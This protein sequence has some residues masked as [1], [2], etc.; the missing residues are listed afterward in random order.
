MK[1]AHQLTLLAA[2]AVTPIAFAQDDPGPRQPGNR[3]GQGGG[4][5]QG[6]SV[7]REVPFEQATKDFKADEGVFTVWRKEE[8][9]LFEIPN[10]LMGRDFLWYGELKGAP[11]GG[12]SGSSAFDNLV[13]WEVRGNKVLLKDISY[14]IKAAPGTAIEEGVRISN[15]DP[16]IAVFDI[17]SKTPK[18]TLIDVSRFLKSDTPE[19]ST[20]AAVPGAGSMD[21]SRTFLERI[22]SFPENINYEILATFNPGATGAANPFSRRQAGGGTQTA[23]VHHSFVLLAEKPMMGRIADSRVG[24]F[25]NSYQDF[26]APGYQG[27]KEYRYINRYRLEKKDPNAKVSE[28]V[29]PIVYYVAKEVPEEW[30]EYVKQGIEDWQPA[31]EQAGFK[32]A[33]IAKD[34]PDDPEWSPEDVR[35]SVVR[36]A[37][38]PIANALGPSVADPRSG[39]I[40][41]A[42]VIMWHDILKLQQEWYFTQASASDPR[43]RKFPY[44]K[45]LMGELMRFVVAHEVGHTLGLPHNGKSSAMIETALLRDKRWTA[46][47]GTCTS[48][49]DYARFNYVAQPGDG[50]AMIPKVG[51][52]DKFAIEWGYMPIN[53]ARTP[54]D[55]Q[56]ELD[57]LAS[58][59]VTDRT[60]RFYDN[61]S[62][63]D[64]TAQAE[65][66]GDDAVI[67]STYGLEN[68]KRIVKFVLPATVSL[69]E[70]YSETSRFWQACLDQYQNYIGHVLSVVGGQEMID[71]RGGRGGTVFN[72][73]ARD[74]QQRAVEWLINN[75]LNPMDELYPADITD[76]VATDGGRAMKL[77]ASSRVLNSLFSDSRINRVVVNGERTLGGNISTE[78]ILTAVSNNIWSEVAARE[79]SIT[80]VRREMQRQWFN[81]LAPKLASSPSELR[82]AV[83]L[84]LE[85]RAKLLKGARTMSDPASAAHIADMIASIDF[86]LANP[87]KMAPAPAAAPA[88]F[89]GRI[90]HSWCGCPLEDQE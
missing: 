25:T 75:V 2:L 40:I 16:I 37:A 26:S 62:S 48:V 49:M 17:K 55:E 71:W 36:W 53:R 27:V 82:G 13:R 43:G 34:A 86:A 69:G 1:F 39:E 89:P 54:W 19:L 46:E 20:K 7:S 11:N 90:Q 67:A 84:E 42:H 51:K 88:A 58:K 85:K 81:T 6:T 72:P 23:L 29:K 30:R 87:E 8:D 70:D 21:P 12:Y 35:Y 60:L 31:F 9:V 80:P 45:E 66:L 4:P 14:R 47:N 76:K 5:G 50:A 41:S 52:Y 57:K 56:A 33:I 61:F 3:P 64:P 83:R 79:S 10:T 68:L 73:V 74:Y 18:S 77:A 28:V 15:V 24:Y 63:S 22:L 65:A 78:Y 32:N 38:L 59:Q 44:S